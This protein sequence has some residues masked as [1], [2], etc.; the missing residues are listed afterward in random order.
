[1]IYVEATEDECMSRLF[2]DADKLLFQKEWQK[3]IHDWFLAFRPDSPGR[4]VKTINWELDKG[5]RLHANRADS[6]LNTLYKCIELD[7]IKYFSI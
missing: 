5:Q 6:V 3:Y 2:N 1:L 7:E 4:D